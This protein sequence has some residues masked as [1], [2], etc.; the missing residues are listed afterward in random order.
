MMRD[1]ARLREIVAILIRYGWG[2]LTKRLGLTDGF[3][4]K[5]GQLLQP[6]AAAEYLDLPPEVRV[7]LALQELG[8]TF[9]KLGQVLAT[10]ADIFPPRWV[11]EFA[12]LQDQVPPVPFEDLLPELEKSLG[13][14]NELKW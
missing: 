11:A 3:M 4:G 13:K 6:K 10:R 9:V 14:T 12:C 5:A 2:D 7:R 8:P 1:L